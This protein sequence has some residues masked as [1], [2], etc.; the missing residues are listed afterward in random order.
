MYVNVSP[1]KRLVGSKVAYMILRH[2]NSHY[3]LAVTYKMGG[4]QGSA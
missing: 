1:I 4:A 3:V 2:T